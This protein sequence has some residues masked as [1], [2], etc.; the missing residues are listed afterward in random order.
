[1]VQ[2]NTPINDVRT[3]TPEQAVQRCSFTASPTRRRA[4]GR[5]GAQQ[6]RSQWSCSR[7]PERPRGTTSTSCPTDQFF[8]K[9]RFS[10]YLLP[11]KFSSGRS[12]NA[13]ATADFA[14]NSVGNAIEALSLT[15]SLDWPERFSGRYHI[16]SDIRTIQSPR[17][18]SGGRIIATTSPSTVPTRVPSSSWKGAHVSGPRGTLRRPSSVQ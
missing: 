3:V 4:A 15:P 8:R 2:L 1:M 7:M 16:Q 5:V 13:V 12:D 17:R 9:R 6:N 11:V 14:L 18:R 10:C